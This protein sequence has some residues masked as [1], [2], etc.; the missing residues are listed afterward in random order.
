MQNAKSQLAQ[1][2]AY[3]N[4]VASL[5]AHCCARTQLKGST[6]RIKGSA[7]YSALIQKAHWLKTRTQHLSL[8]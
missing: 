5:Y 8:E 3:S 7:D 4:N 6:E 2:K 1:E